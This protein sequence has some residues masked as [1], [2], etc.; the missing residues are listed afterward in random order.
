MP[1]TVAQSHRQRNS[2]RSARSRRARAGL[3]DVR[4]NDLRHSFA[5]VGAAAGLDLPIVGRLLRHRDPKTT[6]RYS[7]IGDDRARRRRPRVRH[8]RRRQVVQKRRRG[9]AV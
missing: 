4:L 7:H 2:D 1:R 3:A 9:C 6:A 5:G 8:H